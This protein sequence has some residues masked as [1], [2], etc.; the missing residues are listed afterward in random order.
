MVNYNAKPFLQSA[1]DAIA[2][3]TDQNYAFILVDN[4]SADGSITNL[5]TDHLANYK[6]IQMDENVGF[7]A[8]NNLAAKQ[9]NSP[10]IALLNPD[11]EALP[12]WLS[13]FHDATKAYPQTAMFAGA[14]LNMEDKHTLDGAGD[15]Y[16]FL[17]IPWRG[18][19]GWPRAALPSTGECFSPCGASALFKR[20]IF[21]D[22]GGFDERFFC[23]CE[24]VDLGF[25][26]RLEGHNCI[27]WPDALAYHVCGGV[28]GVASDFVL[29]HG[30]RN[31]LWTFVKNMPP[32]AL[33]LGLP[34]HLLLAGVLLFRGILR[35]Q[36]APIWHGLKEAFGGLGDV[37]RDR[38]HIQKR[39]KLSSLQVLK[40]MSFNLADLRRHKPVVR[41]VSDDQM[42]RSKVED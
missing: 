12:N 35:G 21:I 8:A 33:I 28:A 40:A 39:R 5:K 20:D 17:G 3:Q 36:G 38:K 30:T 29:R 31:R 13:S 41:P 18:G 22:A 16:F 23:Y 15:C 32:L 26:L 7:A 27:F 14:T 1:I 25:R 37:L 6:L 19:Y 34:V 9:A 24:D 10:W 42:T 4:A 11:T 2:A